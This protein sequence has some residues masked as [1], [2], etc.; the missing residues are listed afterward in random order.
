MV[1]IAMIR[2]NLYGKKTKSLNLCG[3]RDLTNVVFLWLLAEKKREVK[4]QA[5]LKKESRKTFIKDLRDLL[6][7][8]AGLEPARAL[9]PTGF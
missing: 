2:K 5:T 4:Y 7:L 1:W 9:L 3:I 6:V 8:K